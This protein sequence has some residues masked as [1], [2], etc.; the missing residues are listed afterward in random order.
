MC[1]ISWAGVRVLAIS[2]AVSK[3]MRAERPWETSMIALG[4]P[5]SV[6]W[7]EAAC[8]SPFALSEAWLPDFFG[9]V[10]AAASARH[11]VGRVASHESLR[12]STAL[13]FCCASHATRL[14]AL[15][16]NGGV[17]KVGLCTGTMGVRRY[18]CLLR[19]APKPAATLAAVK[20]LAQSR[21]DRLG[22]GVLVPRCT[23]WSSHV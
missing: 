7:C 3:D 1:A 13:G 23:N 12:Q 19:G 15:A 20:T 8:D 5:L 16:R 14:S 11:E 10:V 9:R 2:R 21:V 18:F 4:C 6:A 22:R 17:L